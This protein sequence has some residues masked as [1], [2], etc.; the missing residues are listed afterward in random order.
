MAFLLRSIFLLAA[1]PGGSIL[2]A[3]GE[4]CIL[5]TAKYIVL[6]LGLCNIT[7][8][9]GQAIYSWGSAV[10]FAGQTVCVEVST[11]T[12]NFRV[13][14]SAVCDSDRGNTTIAQCASQRGGLFQTG[15]NSTTFND[16]PVSELVPDSGFDEWNNSEVAVHGT[17]EMSD[18]ALP[19]NVGVITNGINFTAG[20]LPL[21]NQSLL[22]QTLVDND[23]IAERAFGIKIGTQILT[24]PQGGTLI[25]GGYNK[26]SL[27]GPFMNFSM[28]YPIMPV[29]G[30]KECPIQ[31]TIEQLL[32]Q[33]P[34]LGVKLLLGN[35]QTVTACIEP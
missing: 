26:G 15:D 4:N 21:T 25:L 29:G 13:I 12:N 1:L 35:G 14:S 10:T 31:V 11:V 5:P 20:Y 34:T 23:F 2:G 32:Y 7:D 19:I 28:D 22:L 8:S 9:E 30:D 17:L 24:N 3:L 18:V 6:P 27:G 33:S 16:I